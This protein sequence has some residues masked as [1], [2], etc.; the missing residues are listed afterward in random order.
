MNSP[1]V[2]IGV[3]SGHVFEYIAK[4]KFPKAQLVY[5]N[6]ISD[7]TEFLLMV[8]AGKADVSFTG[9]ITADLYEKSNP[10]KIRTLDE[11]ARYCN[12]A[13]MMPLGEFNMKQMMDNALLELNISGKLEAIAKKYVPFTKKYL[14]L[15][16]KP[17]E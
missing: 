9:Q 2:K 11:P 4:E 10:A 14:S 7:D 3:K 5:A 8:Q 6:D 12:G 1:N 15:P 17:F 13:F 16:R